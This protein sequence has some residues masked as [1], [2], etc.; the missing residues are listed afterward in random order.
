M[1]CIVHTELFKG[2]D[3]KLQKDEI[4]LFNFKNLFKNFQ[5]FRNFLFQKH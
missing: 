2:D 1:H 5:L 4:P 3:L